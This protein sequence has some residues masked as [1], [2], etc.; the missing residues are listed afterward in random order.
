MTEQETSGQPTVETP[1][2]ADERASW[3]VEQWQAELQRV[4]AKEKA[5]GR[6]LAEAAL[7]EKAARDEAEAKRK[8][9]EEAGRFEDVKASLTS[10]RDEAMMAREAFRAEAEELRA[11]IAADVAAAWDALPEAVRATFDGDADDVLA[12]KRHMNRMA[13]VIDEMTKRTG[14]EV[15]GNRP[16]PGPSQGAR[17]TVSE[18]RDEMRRGGGLRRMI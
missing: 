14:S 16:S 5:E 15:L 17:V 1:A 6:R 8:R 13:P 12:K 3:T 11:L 7:A 9:D 10:E 18:T 2:V 4:G